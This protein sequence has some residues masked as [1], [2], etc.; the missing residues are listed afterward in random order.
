MITQPEAPAPEVI[1]VEK[2]LTYV[3]VNSRLRGE[4][5][6]TVTPEKSIPINKISIKSLATSPP[7]KDPI[8]NQDKNT[9]GTGPLASNHGNLQK[10][11]YLPWV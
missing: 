11:R 4:T 9:L 8:K 10:H 7:R 1:V 2:R 5:R 6:A 3:S